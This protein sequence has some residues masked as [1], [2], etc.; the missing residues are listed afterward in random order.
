MADNGAWPV[1][2][3]VS[4]AAPQGT[5][6][7]RGARFFAGRKCCRAGRGAALAVG[8]GIRFLR[9]DQLQESLSARF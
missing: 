6:P 9:A 7:A 5:D 2:R 3:A 4:D 1:I 8:L